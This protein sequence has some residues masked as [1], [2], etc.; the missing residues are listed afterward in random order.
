MLLFEIAAKFWPELKDFG[1]AKR[2]I[3]TGEVLTF[4]YSAPL[5]LAGIVWLIAVTDIQVIER[6]W[7][8]L[9]FFAVLM[10]I[11]RKLGFFM[12][13]EI[14]SGRYASSDGSMESMVQWMALFLFGPTSLWL[15]VFWS[16]MDFV[17]KWS[18]TAPVIDRWSRA[19]NFTMYQA[20]TILASLV[21]LAAY[22]FWGGSIPISG[23]SP[24]AILP[25]FGAILVQF[26]VTA[27]I[28][29]AY[30]AYA[31]WS[32]VNLAKDEPVRP[33]LR[34]LVMALALPDLAHPFAILAAG[35]WVQNG[36]ATFLFFIVGLGMVALLTR[37]MSWVAESRRQQSRQLEK[38]EMLGRDIINA[39]P[40]TS[41]LPILLHDH[42][43]AMFP[44]G[45]VMVWIEPERV[46]IQHPDDW[47]V[48]RAAIWGWLQNQKDALSLLAIDPL[49]WKFENSGRAASEHNAIVVLPILD[50]ESSQPIGGVYL[51]LFSLSQP[52]D[53]RSLEN[54]FPASRNLAAQV[55]SALH[56]AEVYAKA[57][58]YQKVSQEL[59]LAGRIQASFLPDELPIFSGWQLSVTVLPARETSGDYFDLI[60]LENGKLGVLIADV[61]DKGLGAAL[62]MALSRTLIRTY[63]IEFAEEPQPDVV[64]FA[65]NGRLLKDARA[66]LF[67]TAFYGVLDPQT[68]IMT[69]ANAGHNPPYLFRSGAG[70]IQALG[71]TGM[72]IGIEEDTLWG[73]ATVQF[74]PGDVLVLYTD[75]IPDALNNQGEIFEN[76]ML[77]ETIQNSRGMGAQ[78]IQDA[79]IHRVQDFV[80]EASQYDDITLMVLERDP[81]SAPGAGEMPLQTI[82]GP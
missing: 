45:R 53:S 39:P 71:Q 44:S 31:V 15:A 33:V 14:R 4:L 20:S 75:G 18:N 30:I 64:F 56:Q 29:A 40:D 79:I 50:V 46:L 25:A 35:L 36:L 3:G 42:V 38:L 24:Q 80:G 74:D 57:L 60:P 70:Q 68:G 61:T 73:Q 41:T 76:R 27:A 17:T 66:N 1:I 8:M 72:P 28:W 12:I 48:D 78:E 77:L 49:P 23:L 32:Q 22:R 59:A 62:Y 26:L 19:R 69:Y 63:A 9:L 65:A 55:A 16:V 13:A 37:Q 10:L 58:A 11:F 21:G 82:A 47:S 2:L 34:F 54:L 7:P 5:A 43:P 81:A 52:W 67:V 6:N 51:E